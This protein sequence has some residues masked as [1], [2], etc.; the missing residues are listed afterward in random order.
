MLTIYTYANCSTCS[1]ATAF[2]RKHDVPFVEKPIRE[3]PPT[4]KEL[5]AMLA[6]VGERKRLF[7]SSGLDYRRMHIG[8]KLT[9]LSDLQVLHLLAANGNLIK[10]PFLLFKD[11]GLIGFKP[12]VWS[13]Q[14]ETMARA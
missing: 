9:Q 10:R 7:N 3:Q 8:E 14:L 2:L 11:G 1:K 5:T 4:L 12:E 6:I 13:E